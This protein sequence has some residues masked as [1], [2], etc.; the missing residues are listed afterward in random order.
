VGKQNC[1][2]LTGILPK[3]RHYLRWTIFAIFARWLLRWKVCE[4]RNFGNML[5]VAGNAG[6]CGKKKMKKSGK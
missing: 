3:L 1:L 5:G 6:Q 4:S 2:R